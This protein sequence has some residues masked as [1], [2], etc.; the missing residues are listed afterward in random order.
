MAEIKDGKKEEEV[1]VKRG[2]VEKNYKWTTEI[3]RNR[4]LKI[5]LREIESESESDRGKERLCA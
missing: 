1:V 3:K 5:K 2:G 4:K